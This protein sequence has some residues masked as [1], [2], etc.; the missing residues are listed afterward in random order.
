MSAFT[1]HLA[2]HTLGGEQDELL[3]PTT[4][5]ALR[6]VPTGLIHDFFLQI[7][8]GGSIPVP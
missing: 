4:P 3:G 7:P 8:V 2:L 5:K 6:N 1:A